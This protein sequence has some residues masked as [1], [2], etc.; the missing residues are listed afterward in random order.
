MLRWST[1]S[2]LKAI[3]VC[4]N[5]SGICKGIVGHKWC[6]YCQ[7]AFRG[8]KPMHASETLAWYCSMGT[9]WSIYW[10]HYD[11]LSS[12]FWNWDVGD[13]NYRSQE[14]CYLNHYKSVSMEGDQVTVKKKKKR[15]PSHSRNGC[16]WVQISVIMMFSGKYQLQKYVRIFQNLSFIIGHIWTNYL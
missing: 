10:L 3:T 4:L 9:L 13:K 2:L 15:W 11:I 5:T 6:S 7:K 1:Y 14:W 8:P 16:S 12:E